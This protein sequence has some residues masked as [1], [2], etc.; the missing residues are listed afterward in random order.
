MRIR[1]Y[2]C[3][4]D[5][6]N[7]NNNDDGDDDH[8]HDRYTILII[9]VI[10]TYRKVKL[11]RLSDLP[12]SH[13]STISGVLGP[14]CTSLREPIVKFSR[15]LWDGWYISGIWNLPGSCIYTM[16][17]GKWYKSGLLP[18]PHLPAQQW[19]YL[20]NLTTMLYYLH[21]NQCALLSLH[22]FYFY[23]IE[24]FLTQVIYKK[25]H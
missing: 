14:V 10:W 13:I 9:M 11:R 21:I 2:G 8:D 7:R 22:L 16:E 23:L 3:K 18:P 15:I 6:N 17:I 25:D 1:S 5:W 4:W 19:L 20:S 12:Y 24:D